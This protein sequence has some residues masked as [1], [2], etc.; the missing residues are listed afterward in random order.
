MYVIG[1]AGH[2]DH[3]K[4]TLVK[5]LT[6]IDPDRLPEEKEREMTIDLG[7]AWLTLPSGREVSIVD[8]PGHERFIKNMLAGVGGIDL[9]LLVVAADESVMPQTLEHLAILDILQVKRGLVVI[10]KSDTVDEELVELVKAEV[11]DSLKGT[12]FEG[13]PMAAVSAYTG[14]GLDELKDMVD[15]MLDST[16]I[17]KD[18][19]RPRLPVDRCFTVAGFGTVV[20]GTLIDGSLSVGQEAKLVLSG[21]KGRIR[22]LQSHRK[23]LEDAAPGRR[24]AVNLSGISRDGV[25]RGEVITST[26][27]LRP[28]LRLDAKLK[29]V[30]DAPRTL[31]HNEGITFHLFTSETPARVRLL[32]TDA[33]KPGE[34]AWGQIH[35]QNPIPAVRGDLFVIRSSDTTLGGGKVVD[36]APTRRHRRL[37]PSVI[38]RL[39]ALDEGA[40]QD[41]LLNAV[42][43]WGPCDINTLSRRANLPKSE[44]L[45]GISDLS[46]GGQVVVLGDPGTQAETLVYSG[47]AWQSMKTKSTAFLEDYHRQHPLRKGIPREEL[48]NRLGLPQPTTLWALERLAGEGVLEQEGAWVRLPGQQATLNASQEKQADAYI[49]ALEAEPFS[50]PTDHPVDAEVLNLLVDDGKVVKINETVVLAASAYKNMVEKIVSYTRENGK[51]TV[52]EGRDLFDTSRKYILPILEYLD[53]QHITRRTGDERV[54]R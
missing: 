35:L 17:R 18:V 20:T 22:N 33:L 36:P 10:T 50:P 16:D 14:H 32:D 47:P 29:L 43:L 39:T 6:N 34:E 48:R 19:G 45:E 41:S 30:R 15:S 21:Q 11:E 23:K 5:A 46:A 53:Q 26:D 8:V 44:V 31:K 7:F 4:S 1:T 40:E 37:V 9:A 54:L 3:G 51:I 25:Q 49:R 24:L 12:T 27:W 2:V 13:S 42:E 28:T 38:E 52:A